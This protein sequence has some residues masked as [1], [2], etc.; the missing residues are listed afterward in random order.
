MSEAIALSDY[1]REKWEANYQAKSCP[2]INKNP[3]Y[4]P[5]G[6]YEDECPYCLV[7]KYFKE[8]K[9]SLTRLALTGSM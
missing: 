3:E 6:G 4:L 1:L 7:V 2:L 5:C 9:T 8:A